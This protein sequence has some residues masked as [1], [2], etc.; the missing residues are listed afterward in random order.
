MTS[1]NFLKEENEI[2]KEIFNSIGDETQLKHL[3]EIFTKYIQKDSRNGPNYFI[4]FLEHY[5]L[6]RPHQHH[7]SKQLMNCVNAYFPPKNEAPPNYLN[8]QSTLINIIMSTEDF[9]A[10]QDKQQNEVFILLREDDIDGFISFLANNSTFDITQQQILPMNE[11]YFYLFACTWSRNSISLIDF[12]CF[13]G[14]LK[15]FKYLLL[16]KCKITKETLRWSIAGGNKEIINILKENGQKFEECL[17]TSVKY[18]RY[19]LTNWLNENYKCEEIILAT[20]IEYYNFEAFFYFLEKNIPFDED[21][22]EEEE[23]T[24]GITIVK[25]GHIP[26]FQYF[27]D[28]VAAGELKYIRKKTSLVWAFRNDHTTIVQYLIENCGLLQANDEGW[29]LLHNA[30]FRGIDSVVRFLIDDGYQ[31]EAQTNEG[32]TPLHIACENGHLSVVQSLIE[33]GANIEARDLKGCTPLHTA[34]SVGKLDIVKYLI[35]Q[36]ADKTAK[37]DSGQTPADLSLS[38]DIKEALK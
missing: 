17:E 38:N 36:G 20:C 29:S 37:T 15:C 25:I 14:S 35:S 19:E 32:K 24:F 10:N 26:L 3:I 11:Y 12:C 16:N 30:S 9:T 23:S 5:S 34:S 33:K 8:P 18:H 13:F 6:C 22:D 28:K 2:V 7:V 21:D 31:I 1:L 27:L 4:Q